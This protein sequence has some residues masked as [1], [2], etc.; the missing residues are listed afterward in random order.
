MP[1]FIAP[2]DATSGSLVTETIGAL[3]CVRTR[4]GSDPIRTNVRDDPVAIVPGSDMTNGT[5]SDPIKTNI[6]NDPV[7][8]A[9]GSETTNCPC[10]PFR[11]SNG[12]AGSK[13]SRQHTGSNSGAFVQLGVVTTGSRQSLRA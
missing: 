11:G 6:R 7:A 10:S 1:T 5:G 2:L 4:S 12:G 3:C 9:P 8:I 13:R